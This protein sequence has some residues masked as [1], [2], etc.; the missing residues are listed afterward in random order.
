M[1]GTSDMEGW[2]NLKESSNKINLFRKIKY[3]NPNR[4]LVDGKSLYKLAD[5]MIGCQNNSTLC[6]DG[7]ICTNLGIWIT[8]IK[9]WNE[10]SDNEKR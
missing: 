7:E 10:G 3:Q 4:R 9:K 6:N 2:L 1:N 5:K 8:K